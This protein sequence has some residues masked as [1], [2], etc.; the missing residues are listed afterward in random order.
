MLVGGLDVTGYAVVLEDL[1][2]VAVRKAELGWT[3]S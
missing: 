2:A 3:G 1:H